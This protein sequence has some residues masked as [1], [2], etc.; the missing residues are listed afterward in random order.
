[1]GTLPIHA[2]ALFAMPL[3]SLQVMWGISAPFSQVT[4]RRTGRRVTHAL[5]D[6]G[7]RRWRR[8]LQLRGSVTF[9]WG[10]VCEWPAVPVLWG[11]VGQETPIY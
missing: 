11:C 10:T 3:E 4:V 8:D 9:R 1:M 5:R 2:S 7:L 6:Q